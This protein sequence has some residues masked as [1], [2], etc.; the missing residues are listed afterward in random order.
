MERLSRHTSLIANAVI[1]IAIPDV[2]PESAVPPQHPP[3]LPADID[4][5]IEIKLERRLE[6]EVAPPAIPPDLRL[7][8]V[9]PKPIVG[10]RGNAHV[11]ALGRQLPQPI[12]HMPHPDIDHTSTSDPS[13]RF[14]TCPVGSPRQPNSGCSRH[15][16]G[17]RSISSPRSFSLPNDRPTFDGRSPIARATSIGLNAM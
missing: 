8:P 9:A 14:A 4:H 7:G 12:Q 15:P 16:N 2:Q 13:F 1:A 5:V 11:H 3:H 6:P 10:R 17:T